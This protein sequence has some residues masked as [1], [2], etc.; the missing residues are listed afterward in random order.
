MLATKQVCHVSAFPYDI[1]VYCSSPIFS[2]AANH[3]PKVVLGCFQG[4]GHKMT[5]RHW[6][7][8]WC[9]F[10]TVAHA[11]L[12][13]PFCMHETHSTSP[14]PDFIAY[15]ISSYLGEQGRPAALQGV[16]SNH[17]PC[18]CAHVLK[19]GLIG[20]NGGEKLHEETP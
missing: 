1:L 16:L 9:T 4:K 17:L 14:M 3:S 15:F 18:P 10:C 20:K 2:Q 6:G 19:H 8:E 5:V 13:V 11:Q 7:R 12:L